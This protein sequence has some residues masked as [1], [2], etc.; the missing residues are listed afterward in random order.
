VIIAGEKDLLEEMVTILESIHQTAA[1]RPFT[2]WQ[3][4]RESV[5]NGTGDYDS[6]QRV[7]D[8]SADGPISRECPYVQF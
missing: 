7:N 4:M 6:N 5:R 3:E 8:Q 1:R 2:K